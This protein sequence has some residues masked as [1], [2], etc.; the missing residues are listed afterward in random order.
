MSVCTFLASNYMLPKVDY[1]LYP[2]TDV[3]DYTDKTYGVYLEW[4]CTDEE[5]NELLKYIKEGL[6][7]DKSIELW[8]VWLG[9]YYEYEDSPVIHKK[10]C[11]IK[12]LTVQDIKELANAEIFNHPDKYIPSRPSFYCLRISR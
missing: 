8:L 4:D 1:F 6:K 9:D 11:S 2:F 5:A 7:K 3:Q 10:V 12:E